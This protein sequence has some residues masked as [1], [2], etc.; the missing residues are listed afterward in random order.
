MLRVCGKDVVVE[1]RVIRSARLDGDGY[2]FLDA[3][4]SFLGELKQ[5]SSRVDIFTFVQKVS[6]PEPKFHYSMEWDN[7]AVLRVTSFE[8]WW[9]RQIGFKARNHARQA[10]KKGVV[11]REVPFDESLV[12]GIREVYNECPVRQGR[13]ARHYGKDF[14]TVYREAATF[15]DRSIFIGAFLDGALIGFIKMV[16]DETWGQANLMNVLSMVRYRSKGPSNALMAQAVRCCAERGI[17]YLLYNNF[18][19]GKKQQD[20]ALQ[21]KENN[22]FQKVEVPRYYVPLTE[23]GSLALRWGLHKRL[24]ERVPEPVLAKVRKLRNAWYNRQL[25]SVAGAS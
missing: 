7:F 8:D 25:K 17:P 12:Q 23:I 5:A 16:A 10:E 3:P 4:E 13:P 19:Y 22:G 15:L 14:A 9:E 2:E 18:H 6:E 20:G 24:V 1:G 21:F 11:I